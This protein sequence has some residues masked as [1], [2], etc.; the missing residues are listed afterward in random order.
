M[1]IL[2]LADIDEL[3]WEYGLGKA[4]VLLSC[5]D[6]YDQVI[7][8]ASRSYNC[9]AVFAVKGN[10]DHNEVFKNP[11]ID[12]HRNR[13][14]YGGMRFGGFNGSWKYKLKNLSFLAPFCFYTPQ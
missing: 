5:G 4:D 9:H 1:R 6:V 2:A 11:V 13:K 8:E 12:L 14:G 7:L 10:H 3:H